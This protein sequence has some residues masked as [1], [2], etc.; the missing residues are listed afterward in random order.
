MTNFTWGFIIGSF[1][2]EPLII[3]FVYFSNVA[4]FRDIIL[5]KK[6]REKLDRF[7][8]GDNNDK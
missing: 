3:N 2:L 5:T 6:N 1:I 7:Y 8:G 4:L